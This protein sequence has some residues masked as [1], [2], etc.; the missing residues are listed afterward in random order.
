MHAM[1]GSWLIVKWM[2]ISIAAVY[3]MLLLVVYMRF[4]RDL[5]RLRSG[6]ILPAVLGVFISVSVP[7]IFEDVVITRVCFVV[8]CAI[9]IGGIVILLRGL[10][11][12]NHQSLL[13]VEG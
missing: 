6:L 9:Y 4:R 12:E 10:I 2:G 3:L 11:Q 1:T 8:A 5:S 13:K 7:S